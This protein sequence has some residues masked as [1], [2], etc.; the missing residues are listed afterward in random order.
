M[1]MKMMNEG[2]D[3]EDDDEWDDN[4]ADDEWDDNEADDEGNDNE[5]EDESERTCTGSL[6][7]WSGWERQVWQR[8]QHR[9][10]QM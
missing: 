5:D 4:E 7:W 8:R 1:I 9:L 2:N 6:E 10:Q 3:N